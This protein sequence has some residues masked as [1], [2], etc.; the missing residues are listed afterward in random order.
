MALDIT[1]GRPDLLAVRNAA[2]KGDW[3]GLMDAI[4]AGLSDDEDRSDR[5]EVAVQTLIGRWKVV[6]PA[7]FEQY[8]AS[9]GADATAYLLRGALEVERAWLLRGGALARYT[10]AEQMSSFHQGLH[11][12]EELLQ[13]SAAL[14]PADASPWV[15]LLQLA[16]GLEIGPQRTGER[17]EELAKR[18][19]YHFRGHYQAVMSVTPHWGYSA[20]FTAQCAREWTDGHPIGSPTHALIH[21]ANFERWRRDNTGTPLRKDIDALERARQAST[22]MNLAS[23]ERPGEIL[24]HN[25]AAAW[26]SVIGDRKSARPH[27]ALIRGRATRWPWNDMGA[28]P[29]AVYRVHRLRAALGI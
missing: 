2:R 18:N 26:F 17:R 15:W 12:A 22:R 11:C 3:P 10:G 28:N 6:V 14:A 9:L 16:R 13:A 1:Y 23:C 19:P 8:I 20:A 4:K 21:I 5:V 7:Q 27:L 29:M 24:A 25:Y